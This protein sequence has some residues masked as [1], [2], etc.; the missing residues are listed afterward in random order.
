MICGIHVESLIPFSPD[1]ATSVNTNYSPRV[2]QFYFIFS[3][4]Q[5]SIFANRLIESNEITHSVIILSCSRSKVRSALLSRSRYWNSDEKETYFIDLF[6][7]FFFLSFFPSWSIPVFPAGPWH[8]PFPVA[9]F[10]GARNVRAW[11]ILKRRPRAKVKMHRHANPKSKVY[12]LNAKWVCYVSRMRVLPDDLQ[13]WIPFN[14][15]RAL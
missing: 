2:S 3:N 13:R 10:V 6:F 11:R 5:V 8:L 12:I 14:G 4:S 15:R 1:A 9:L 7:S